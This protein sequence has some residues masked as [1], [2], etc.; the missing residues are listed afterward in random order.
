[1]SLALTIFLLNTCYITLNTFR[2]MLVVRRQKFWAPVLAVVEE[3][4]YVMALAIALK[5]ISNPVNIAAY[6]LGFGLGIYLGILIEDRIALGY[7]NFQ[8]TI[9]I[10]QD[11]PD[12]DKNRGLPET[13]R[14]SGYGVTETWGYGHSG[15]RLILSILAPRSA[16]KKLMSQIKNLSPN[17]F[18][19]VNEPTELSGG[20]W[21]KEV[22]KRFKNAK[23][24]DHG[25][26]LKN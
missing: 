11:S 6:C 15:A 25:T 16:S 21:S 17:A 4:V 18:I 14:N 13:L 5:N 23:N 9:P 10:N 2:T 1:M 19:M 20:F 22:S 26:S 7:V 3:L 12:Y 24:Q 8:V